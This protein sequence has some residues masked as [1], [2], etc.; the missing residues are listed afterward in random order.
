MIHFEDL[1]DIKVHDQGAICKQKVEYPV[2]DLKSISASM[3]FACVYIIWIH[4]DLRQKETAYRK[5]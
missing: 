4:E 1:V 3:S 5:I 2:K